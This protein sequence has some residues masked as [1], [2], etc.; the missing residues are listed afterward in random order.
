MVTVA[1]VQKG[2]HESLGIMYLSAALKEHGHETCLFIENMERDLPGA[3]ERS[4]PQVI[5]FSVITGSHLWARQRAKQLKRRFPRTIMVMGG[6]HP[7]FYPE[8]ILHGGVDAICIGEGEG[9]IVDLANAIRDSRDIQHIPNIWV[10]K[11]DRI[12]KNEPRPLVDDL[13]LLPFPDRTLYGKYR[14]LAKIP[15]KAFLTTRGCPHNCAF[16]FNHQFQQLYQGRGKVV[17][18]RTPGNVIQ[19][20]LEVKSK[21]KMKNVYFQDDTFI[22]DKTWLFSFLDEYEKRVA[23]PFICFVRADLVDEQVAGRL[24]RAGCTCVHFGVESGVEEMRNDVLRKNLTN[25]Q[26]ERAARLF[27]RH[28]I[29]FLTYNIVGLPGET[30]EMATQTMSFNA[31]L[32][33]DLPWVSFLTPYPRTSIGETMARDGLLPPGWNVDCISGS[34]FTFHPRTRADRAIYN[35]QRLFFWGVKFPRT[36]PLIKR[37]IHVPPNVMFDVMFYVAELFVFKTSDNLPWLTS[38]KMALDFFKTNVA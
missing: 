13:D 5:C 2:I 24:K 4:A 16:C 26:I 36:I 18:R 29:K 31:T 10:R 6:P 28:H 15:R 32:R 21:Y 30:L 23:L 33:T 19:E 38:I 7:T 9:A 12:I 27:K 1:F 11:D 14:V 37:L 3:M 35:L 20:I 17:R 8:T 34:F 22:L 25:G